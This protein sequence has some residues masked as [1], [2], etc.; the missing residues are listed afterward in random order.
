MILRALIEAVKQGKISL[1]GAFNS[2]PPGDTKRDLY[3]AIRLTCNPSDVKNRYS[4]K[5]CCV[6]CKKK[7]P[8]CLCYECRC[9]KCDWYEVMIRGWDT[10]DKLQESRCGYNRLHHEDTSPNTANSVDG[11]ETFF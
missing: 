9:T 10:I 3:E 6:T 4:L 8:G 11:L 7:H 2:S 1:T 5:G